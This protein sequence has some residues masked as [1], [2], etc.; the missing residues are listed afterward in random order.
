MLSR[1]IAPDKNNFSSVLIRQP[2]TG[3][4]ND[5]QERQKHETHLRECTTSAVV[6]W[7]EGPLSFFS[8]P[9][10]MKTVMTSMKGTLREASQHAL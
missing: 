9:L 8:C 6:G 1:T 7:G 10:D 2:F 4:C 5:K 3:K